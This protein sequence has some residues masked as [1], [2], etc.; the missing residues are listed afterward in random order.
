MFAW[1]GTYKT[2]GSKVIFDVDIAWVQSWVGTTRT[3]QVE[4]A[5]NKLTVTTPPFK[6]LQMAKT[7]WLSPEVR[8]R[9]WMKR[10]GPLRRRGQKASAAQEFSFA[11]PKKLLQQYRPISDIRL[12]MHSAPARTGWEALDAAEIRPLSQH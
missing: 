11:T 9:Y 4:V 6:A 8:D 1:G 5:S 7:L 10:Y 2:D 12:L 3:Y